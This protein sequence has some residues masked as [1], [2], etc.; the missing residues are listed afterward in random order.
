MLPPPSLTI[1]VGPQWTSAMYR[2][3]DHRAV[4]RILRSLCVEAGLV[5]AR[6]NV[7]KVR[8]RLSA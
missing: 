5:A 1:A 6:S 4:R 3:D 7:E 2:V 8:D